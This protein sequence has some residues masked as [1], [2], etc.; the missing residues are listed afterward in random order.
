MRKDIKH[1]NT[2][3]LIFKRGEKY[4]PTI[5]DKLHFNFDGVWSSEYNLIHV[6]TDSG[7]FEETLVASRDLVETKVRGS[8]KPLLQKIDTTPLEFDMTIA[9]EGVYTDD[10]LNNV[11][12]WLF[13]NQYKPLYF[14]GKEDKIYMCI[15]IG[16][17]H[18]Y[19]NGLNQGYFTLHMRCDSPNVYSPSIT[20]DA[21]EIINSG[22]ITL[23]NDGHSDIFPEISFLKKGVGNIIIES[24]D[25][26]G[27]IFEIRDLTDL[28]DIYINCE[29]EIIETDAIGV[30][31][32]DNIIGEFPRLLYGENRFKITGN[33][34]IQFRYKN[35]Y[36]F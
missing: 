8:D 11:I 5:K 34:E 13:T 33:C 16:D 1:L 7:M 14:E 26:G 3:C 20:T 15:A 28:E 6:V 25:D 2:R 32:Y 23:I 9:F 31:R 35:K 21:E 19:H 17:P 24:L 36:R 10:D 22:I 18:I 30:C 12:R 29:K 4:M 27:N